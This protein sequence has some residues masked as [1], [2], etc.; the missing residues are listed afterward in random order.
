VSALA[1]AITFNAI[2]AGSTVSL[3]ADGATG[4]GITGGD[5]TAGGDISLIGQAI[6]LTGTAQTPGSLT[7]FTIDG[8]LAIASSNIAGNIELFVNGDVSGTYRAGGNV[9]ILATGDAVLEADAAGTYVS[10]AGI[11]SEGYVF[12][13]AEGDATLTDSSAATM[14]GVR[15]GGA[16]SVTGGTAGE[17]IFILAGTTATLANLTAGDDLNVTSGG[18]M[19]ISNAATTGSGADDRSIVYETTPASGSSPPVTMLQI[20]SSAPDLSNV[21]LS[22]ACAAIAAAG[23]SAFSILTATASGTA[24]GGGLLEAGLAA[25]IIGSALA[26]EAVT[27]GTDA[28]LTATLGGVT[29]TGAIAAGHDVTVTAP[30]DIAAAEVDAGD[31]VLLSAGGAIS[32]GAALADGSGADDE[33]TGRKVVATASGAILFDGDISS[34]NDTT[35]TGA[36]IA[37]QAIDAGG[38]I[39]LT[40]T[41][42]GGGAIAVS[43]AAAGGYF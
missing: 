16:T 5:I 22:A 17:D 9:N 42:G 3:F 37:A 1:Q 23:V 27:A 8:D 20:Q 28:V 43:D 33:G 38:G 11:P 18:A 6:N 24:T 10:S 41:G 32:A 12:V 19:T 26:V 35:L 21:T 40:A 13:D 7:A 39:L 34:A 36:S 30:G 25:S 14:L 2:E 31:D 29:A 15:S 4:S